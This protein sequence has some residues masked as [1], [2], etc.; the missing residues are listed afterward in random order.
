[1]ETFEE[2]LLK[3]R[4]T[5]RQQLANCG[6]AS[7]PG[8]TD[9]WILDQISQLLNRQQKTPPVVTDELKDSVK[10]FFARNIYK[11][12]DAPFRLRGVQLSSLNPRILIA[13]PDGVDEEIDHND[14]DQEWEKRLFEL[15]KKFNVD[16]RLPHWC[17][18]K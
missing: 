10:D 14:Q 12:Y 15:G 16:L 5:L 9:D 18:G 13:I 1:M 7:N 4:Q 6:V 2:C 11:G 8:V 17:Y 3:Y